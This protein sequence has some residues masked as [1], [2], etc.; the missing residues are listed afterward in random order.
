[1]TRCWTQYLKSGLV[2]V[3][4]RGRGGVV[5]SFPWLA[6]LVVREEL[7]KVS[8]TIADVARESVGINVVV[9]NC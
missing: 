1:M 8:I 9:D 5:H 3:R 6:S 2:V 4:E 7:V